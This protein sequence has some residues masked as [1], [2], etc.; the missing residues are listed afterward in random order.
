MINT[1]KLNAYMMSDKNSPEMK[2]FVQNAVNDYLCRTDNK[3]VSSVQTAFLKDLHLLK[4]EKTVK[5]TSMV[6]S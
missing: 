2:A 1:K 4:T 6:T 3:P 5:K